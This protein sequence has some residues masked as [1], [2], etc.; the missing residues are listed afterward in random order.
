MKTKICVECG[1]E[2]ERKPSCVDRDWV[3]QKFCSHHCHG[4]SRV[5]S[6]TVTFWQNVRKTEDCWLWIG[7]GAGRP[8]YRYG[9]IRSILFPRGE[10]KAHRFSYELAHGPIPEGMSVCHRCD[11]PLCV[12]PDHL[13]LGS[14][15]DNM[16]D[17]AA[18]RRGTL[19]LT[20]EQEDRVIAMYLGGL[21]QKDIAL[22]FDTNQGS[23]S[24]ILKRRGAVRTKVV[25]MRCKHG[26]DLSGANLVICPGPRGRLIRDC[27]SCRKARWQRYRA[28][29]RTKV[30]T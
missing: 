28:K 12:N 5:K 30:T 21:R 4:L 17:M 14:H 15:S 29:R 19:L 8:P 2:F 9:T 7:Y 10:Q 26:H 27:A 24:C 1:N 25:K 20:A 13:F 18:K 3:K 22:E 6:V 11:N 23:I 16:R